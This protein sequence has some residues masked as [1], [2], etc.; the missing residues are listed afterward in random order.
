MNMLKKLS[1]QFFQG[2]RKKSK[3]FE[4]WY[5][6]ISGVD[7][8]MSVIAGVSLGNDSHAF[9]MLYDNKDLSEYVRYPLDT[10]GFS[11]NVFIKIDKNVFSESRFSLDIESNK[12]IIRA[13]IKF[14]NIISYPRK[15]IHR[16][17][18]GLLNYIPFQQCYYDIANIRSNTAGSVNINGKSYSINGGIGYVEKN[19]G[20]SI[21]KAWTWV[22]ANRFGDET[23]ITAAVATVPYMKKI[24]TGVACIVYTGGKFY[25]LSSYK[26]A[27]VIKLD[28][29]ELCIAN[30]QYE[31]DLEITSKGG[32]FVKAPVLGDMSRTIMSEITADVKAK[33]TDKR[34]QKIIFE[35]SSDFCG[36]EKVK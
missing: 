15:I 24:F 25:N 31:L 5:Y 16:S 34:K 3:Y 14:Q 18:M 36:Y 10:V 8:T 7:Y 11:D 29:K 12:N 2:T 28:D 30:N 32:K 13:D 17:I 19:W 4:G 1:P 22:Q 35:G 6:K 27:K 21:P 26:F 23:S 33:L 20:T 9:I